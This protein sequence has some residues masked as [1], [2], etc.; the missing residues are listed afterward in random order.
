M[1]CCICGSGGAQLPCDY[2]YPDPPPP[3]TISGPNTVWWFSGA[4]P[5]GYNTSITL[6]SSGGSATTWA[7]TAG[8]NEVTLSS[9]S[10]ASITVESSGTAFSSSA[11]DVKITATANNDT[12][13]AFGVTT[14]KPYRLVAGAI[15][16]QCDST[17]GYIDILN[18]TI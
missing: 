15:V 18:Y 3:P 7:V 9:T 17:Y 1:N 8:A 10:G 2:C 4:T 12:S 16:N 13:P 14:R 11:G 6:T 5:S